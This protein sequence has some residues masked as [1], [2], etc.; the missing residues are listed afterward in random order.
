MNILI[1][2]CNGGIGRALSL[3]YADEGHTVTGISR[4]DVDLTDWEKMRTFFSHDIRNDFNL[5]VHCAAK[6]IV[7]RFEKTSYVSFREI[8]E[9]NVMGT[10]N[11]LKCVIP[12]VVPGGNIILFSSLSAFSPRIGQSAYATSKAALSGMV[13]VLAQELLATEK[14][15]FLLAPGLVETGMPENMMSDMILSAAIDKI[16]LRRTCTVAEIKTTIDYAVKT[17]Y[18]SGQT[19]HLN[20]AYHIF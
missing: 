6:N 12:L 15:I 14:Y 2:G 5:V 19:I 17:P 20:G 7:K 16:P 4:S 8:I 9:S 13:K 18:L 10:F 3:R 1:T 11:L